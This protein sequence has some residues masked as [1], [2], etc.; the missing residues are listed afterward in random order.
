MA[1]AAHAESFRTIDPVAAGLAAGDAEAERAAASLRRTPFEAAKQDRLGFVQ[2]AIAQIAR[3]EGA[4]AALREMSAFLLDLL[5]LV[6]RDPALELAAD[7]LY[8][9]AAMLAADRRAGP[10]ALDPR[11]WRLLKDAARRFRLRL[12]AACPSGEAQLLGFA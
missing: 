5:T 1:A 3:G 12:D 6:E 2:G 9:A 11:R 8:E 7:D 10:N 4:P